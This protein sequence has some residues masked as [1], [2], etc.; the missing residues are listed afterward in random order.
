MSNGEGALVVLILLIGIMLAVLGIT[1][2]VWPTER[3]VS[4]LVE[5]AEGQ[6]VSRRIVVGWFLLMFG[7]ATMLVAAMAADRPRRPG[8]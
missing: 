5:L 1:M 2:L 8:R 7:L 6:T 4:N 3:L